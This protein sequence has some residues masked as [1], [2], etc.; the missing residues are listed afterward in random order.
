[1]TVH[2]AQFHVLAVH[3]KHL[4]HTFHSFHT[5]MIV[6]VFRDTTLIVKKFYTE[7]IEIRFGGRPQMGIVDSV[8][9]RGRNSIAHSYIHY[10]AL[11]SFSI[12]VKSYSH[13]FRH[14]TAHVA[15]LHG[16]SNRSLGKVGIGL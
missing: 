8:F 4:S 6:K 16:G 3:L 12:D 2:S 1:M 14:L 7:R 13:T 5:E 15:Y 9:Q 11:N 10:L